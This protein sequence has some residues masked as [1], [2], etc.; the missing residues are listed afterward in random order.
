MKFE[1]FV[2]LRYLRSKRR[3]RFISLISIISIA[4]VSVG[5]ITLIIVM[6]V[7]TGF[8]IA[9][10]ETII[11]NR[12]HLTIY[13]NAGKIQDYESVIREIESLCPEII[14]SGPVIQVEALFKHDEY[15]TGGLILGVDPERESKVTDLAKNLT[16]E[17]GRLFGKGKL[18]GEK[19]IVLGYRLANRIGAR[20]GSQLQIVT[21]RSI[22]RPFIGRQ[23]GSQLWLSV[24]GISHARMSEFDEIYAF[25]DLQTA[26]MLTGEKGVDAIH[27]KLTN[28]FLASTVASKIREHLPYRT[29]TW[30]EDQQAFFDALRQEKLAMF[31]I[32]AFI[33][34][35]AAFNITST[36]IMIVMEKRRDIGILRTLGA[37]TGSILLIF[38]LQGLFIGVIGTVIGLC[39]GI[40]LA[41][42]INP[43][44]QF[45]AHLLGLDLFNSTI[46]YFEG[47]PVAIIP[48]DVACIVVS[49]VILTFLSTLYPAYSAARVNPVDAIRY[50]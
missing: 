49:A 18:P 45:I 11:G 12:S 46:Y 1:A 43:I 25:V 19:E 39:V 38:I 40:V 23:L 33:V 15:T 35:V 32:L 16:N 50:E 20:I 4:G 37:S 44:A 10:R 6:S 24:S 30:Y 28:P 14:A 5:V 3:N 9:L 8:D 26:Y 41:W 34:L 31:I 36:L 29:K 42:N 13:D 17:G 48:F 21:A 27:V 2:A 22:I 7:M 47:I